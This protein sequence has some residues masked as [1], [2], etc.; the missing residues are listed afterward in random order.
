MPG[1]NREKDEKRKACWEGGG[2]GGGHAQ[3][4]GSVV[5]VFDVTACISIHEGLCLFKKEVTCPEKLFCQM[6]P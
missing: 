3:A 4:S 6:W 5:H 1:W 2:R